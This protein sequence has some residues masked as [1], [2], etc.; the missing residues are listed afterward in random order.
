MIRGGHK[1]KAGT[2]I[3]TVKLAFG[4]AHCITFIYIEIR[5]LSKRSQPGQSLI[6]PLTPSKLISRHFSL[7]KN[8]RAVFLVSSQQYLIFV[9]IFGN[10]TFSFYK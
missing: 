10:T 1:E 7:Q 2:K 3:I 9:I 5:N 6:A 8:H 4:L